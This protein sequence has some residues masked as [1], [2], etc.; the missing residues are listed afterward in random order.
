MNEYVK[1]QHFYES[2]VMRIVR[3]LLFTL[4]AMTVF[5]EI[6]N[7]LYP[8]MWLFLLSILFMFEIFMDFKVKR[9]RPVKTADTVTEESAEQALT[10]PA[11]VLY[12]TEVTPDGL[13]QQLAKT[14]QGRFLLEK[15]TIEKKE[16]QARPVT[17]EAVLAYALRLVKELKGTYITTMDLLASYL[18]LS[19]QETKLLFGKEVKPEDLV[20]ILYW[21]RMMYPHEEHP[22]RHTVHFSGEG[23]GEMLVNGW[24]P[25][26]KNFAMNRTY[27][28][29]R[30]RPFIEAR[31]N[32]YMQMLEG[33]SKAE[34]NN[35]LLVGDPGAGKESLV[36][37]LIHDSFEGQ[38]SKRLNHKRVLELMV[39]ALI[40]GASDK[41]ELEARVEAIIAEI[42]HAGNIIL[43]IPD[44]EN[45][46]GSSSF[47]VNLAGALLP[48]LKGG[49]MPVIA[50][51]TTGNY[52]TYMQENPV[53]EVFT[54][55]TIEP[56]E[57]DA[58]IRMLLDK[59]GAVEEKYSAGISYEAVV[60][61]VE[62][63]GVYLP[64][65]VLPGSAVK[66]L[67]DTAN[68]VMVASEAPRLG[69]RRIVTKQR[70]LDQV[71]QKTHIAVGLPDKDESQ[72]LLHLE[73]ALHERVIGQDE[74]VR[75]VSEALRRVRSGLSGGTKPISFLFLGPTGVGKTET[76]KA[77]ATAYFGGEDRILRLDMSEYTDD[78]GVKRLLGA[79][80]GQGDERGEL[81][82]KIHDRPV[83]LVLLDEFEKAHPKILDLFLQVLDDG[84]LTDNKGRTVSFANALIIATSNAGSEFIRQAVQAGDAGQGGFQGKLLEYLQS[85]HLFK[86]ELLNRFDAIVTFKPLAEREVEEVA[87][88]L[89]AALEKKLREQDIALRIGEDVVASVAR[90]GYDAQFGARP[91]RRYIQ[92]TLEDAIAQKKLAGEVNRG[93][94]VTVSVGEGGALQ[95]QVT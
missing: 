68:S 73:E 10:W 28:A 72:K 62:Q 89:L 19:E 50:T 95:Y 7:S 42:S 65:S 87:K 59:A 29:L 32:E 79:P 74:A 78:D 80:P 8:R 48:Y 15:A 75:A 91:L 30:E 20:R 46:L 2:G 64:D 66:L 1:L 71:R 39:G 45:I 41:G 90:S 17:K 86:P 34:A 3:V 11:L 53:S 76:A 55:I 22:G 81:T 63:A 6:L 94:T 14:P 57:K 38:L 18:L 5:Y 67:S 82:D 69:K 9:M 93:S 92:N 43:Y 33:L 27:P 40:A 52:K 23:L 51:M 83:S 58:A 24:T 12:K 85:G 13:V 56:P 26:T 31:E 70:V 25:E 44:F 36:T 37:K 47:N 60:T 21:A 49:S 4:L 16:L 77:L 88:L 54:V 61:A 35:I 84:R